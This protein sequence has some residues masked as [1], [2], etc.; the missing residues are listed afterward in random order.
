MELQTEAPAGL[1]SIHQ[2]ILSPRT[3]L[4]FPPRL[5][6]SIQPLR[7]DG[8]RCTI[9]AL[10][11]TLPHLLVLQPAKAPTN[12]RTQQRYP[13]PHDHIFL[14]LFSIFCNP[15]FS[16]AIKVGSEALDEKRKKNK[17][18]RIHTLHILVYQR[19]ELPSTSSQVTRA[20]QHW[21]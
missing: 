1:H 8:G 15:T 11:R 9:P 20:A 18:K 17:D 14:I 3:I 19:L 16:C 4:W 10:A 7:R 13:R 6:G 12:G 2:R 21:T 5:E